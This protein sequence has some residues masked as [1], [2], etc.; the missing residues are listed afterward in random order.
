[1]KTKKSKLNVLVVKAEHKDLTNEITILC[2]ERTL[3]RIKSQI[4]HSERFASEQI[5][6]NL[7][8]FKAIK[9]AIKIVKH[10]K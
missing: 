4:K 1:M 7:N 3:S 2:L 9:K 8:D 6:E 10:Y 5:K